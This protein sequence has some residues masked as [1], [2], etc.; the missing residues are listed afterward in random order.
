MDD[1]KDKLPINMMDGILDM[2]GKDQTD[3]ERAKLANKIHIV[4]DD[5]MPYCS[6][7]PVDILMN[8]SGSIRRLN[9]GQLTEL[10]LNFCSDH[11]QR[12]IKTLSSM[13]DKE[14]II[15]KYLSMVNEDQYNFFY[16]MYNSYSNSINVKGK[17]IT[18]VD[19]T[20]KIN[21]IK[22]IEENGFYLIKPPHAN[23][24]YETLKR[25]YTEFEFIK[26][27][28]LYID[29]FGT[30][31]RRVIKDGIVGDQYILVLKHNS[32]KN[33]SESKL[34]EN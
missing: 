24:R 29:I 18:F 34:I 26:P 16:D 13:E 6:E 22:D 14:K 33:H 21:F 30:K 27:L 17:D 2:M 12:Y 5:K 23:I 4:D 8:M 20:S 15:F 31:R 32:S 3:E 11:I 28:P 19:N 25:I 1:T 9:T 10:E 7:F